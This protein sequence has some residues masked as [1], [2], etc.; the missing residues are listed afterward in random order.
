MKIK[1]VHFFSGIIL[2]L[3]VAPHLYNHMQSLGGIESHISTM[4]V[5]RS[6]YRNPIVESLLLLAVVVQ[7]GSGISLYRKSRKNLSWFQ[8]L[9][10]QTGLYLAFFLLFHVT[11]VLI[12]RSILHLDTNFYFGAAGLNAF[13]FYL[14]FFPYYTLAILSFFGHI[15]SIHFKNMSHTVL[16]V[17]PYK[18]S[19]A[20]LIAGVIIT[21]FTLY[22]MTNGFEG[23]VMPA[24]YN[25]MI[26]K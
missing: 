26:G 10:L 14:F 25:V 5:L 18:Q 9:H 21:A 17:S 1:N 16:G 4:E 23:V 12:G 19:I 7:I 6:I 13:P 20:L 2:T 24:E 3:F 8:K 15:A 22:G 11:A